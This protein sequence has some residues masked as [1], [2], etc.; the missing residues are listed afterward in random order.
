MFYGK[1]EPM[2]DQEN[3]IVIAGA[4][5]AGMYAAQALKGTPNVTVVDQNPYFEFIP[6]IHELISGN[7]TPQDLQL[8]RD[9]IINS[10]GHSWKENRIQEINRE[11][12]Q[13]LLDDGSSLSYD[14]LILGIGGVNHDRGVP[15]VKEH[16]FP[17][18]SVSDCQKIH[19]HL[20]ILSQRESAFK[21]TIVGAGVEGLEALGEL[22]RKYGSNPGIHIDVI[23]A[24]DQI[25][26]GQPAKINRE[27]LQICKKYPVNF[28]FN[29]RVA[30]VT[31]DEVRLESGEALATDLVIWTGGVK[32]NPLL[33]EAHLVP[34]GKSWA[35]VN[36]TLRSTL[37]ES[38][39]IVGDNTSWASKGEKQAYHA[40]EMGLTAGKNLQRALNSKVLKP[41]RAPDY[42]SAYSFGNLSG[43]L[44]YK[45]QVLAGPPVGGMKE[46]IY[47]VNMARVQGPALCEQVPETIGRGFNGVTNYISELLGSPIGWWKGIQLR[48]L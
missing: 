31:E 12:K 5:F 15:G 4:G 1:R 23:E 32:V 36:K 17:F 34:E 39:F 48:W 28:H 9:P 21:V 3:K 47:Q 13:L 27:V 42:P 22:L 7:K 43:F 25:L 10:L 24:Q 44:I 11:E 26:P 38:I 46:T 33:V 35:P 29:A 40:I 6:N 2:V 18:K 37:D 19:D 30:E 41:F 8:A 16:T 20:E 14:Y 45:G